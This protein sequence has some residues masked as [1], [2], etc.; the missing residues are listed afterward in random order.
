MSHGTDDHRMAH[1]HSAHSAHSAHPI[2]P[3][4]GADR[5][6]FEPGAAG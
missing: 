2:L 1:D 4:F 5:A 3:G 6:R